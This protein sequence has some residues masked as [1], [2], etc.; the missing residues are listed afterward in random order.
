[1]NQTN[2]Y[3]EYQDLTLLTSCIH[4]Y[5][6]ELTKCGIKGLSNVHLV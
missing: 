5:V 2:L 4:M 1:M 3:F 6:I